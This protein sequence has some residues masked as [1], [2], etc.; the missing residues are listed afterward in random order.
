[1]YIQLVVAARIS[2]LLTGDLSAPF[3]S[4]PPFPGATE[5]AHSLF[6]SL[7]LSLYIYIYI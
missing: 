2:K 6:L 5:V 3:N 4:Y 1:M 7:S